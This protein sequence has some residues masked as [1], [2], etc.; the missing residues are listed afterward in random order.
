M[1]SFL[2]LPE[3]PQASAPVDAGPGTTP[4]QLVTRTMFAVNRLTVPATI[5]MILQSAAQAAEPV[6]LGLAIDRAI[7]GGSVRAL[8]A[9]IAS[10]R[11][12]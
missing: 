1:L 7:G 5:L 8:L 10:S 12:R 2:R 3:T 11:W 6:V 4:R 9:W